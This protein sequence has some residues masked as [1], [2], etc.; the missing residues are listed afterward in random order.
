[1]TLLNTFG[2]IA[3]L[4][5]EKGLTLTEIRDVRRQRRAL[6]DLDDRQLRDIGLTPYD[7]AKEISR[8]VFD[9]PVK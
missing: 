4:S 6:A 1:M 9:V 3:G 8:S 5:L 7:V 2:R